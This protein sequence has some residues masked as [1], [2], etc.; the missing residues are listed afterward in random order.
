[1]IL[2]QAGF[3]QGYLVLLC[4]SSHVGLGFQA[5]V[6]DSVFAEMVAALVGLE[7]GR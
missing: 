4:L 2:L 1:M 6:F 7:L 3:V 5:G